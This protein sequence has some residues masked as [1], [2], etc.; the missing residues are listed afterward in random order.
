VSRFIAIIHGWHVHS[1][2]FNVHELDALSLAEAEK[3]ACWLKGRR[4]GGVGSTDAPMW[5]FRL[6]TAST[7][8]GA[9]P[10]ASA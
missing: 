9:S 5:S 1:N 8:P 3:E 2:G 10:G 4:E 6:A 7:F